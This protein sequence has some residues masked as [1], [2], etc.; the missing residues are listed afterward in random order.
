MAALLDRVAGLRFGALKVVQ[1]IQSIV[2]FPPGLAVSPGGARSV[3]Q[4]C[5]VA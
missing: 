2:F 5:F 1:L 4:R 3:R